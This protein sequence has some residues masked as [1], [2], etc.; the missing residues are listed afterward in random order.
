M[1]G[2]KKVFE[3]EI[4]TNSK[5]RW[6]CKSF[7]EDRERYLDFSRESKLLCRARI[8]DVGK[9][10]SNTVCICGV[11]IR[12]VGTWLEHILLDCESL[13]DIRDSGCWVGELQ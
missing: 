7:G 3:E 13:S 2:R 8:N 11:E 4:G 1:N 9:Y 5:L 12:E 10:G 6:Y